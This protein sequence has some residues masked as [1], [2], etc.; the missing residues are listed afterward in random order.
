MHAEIAFVAE[1]EAPGKMAFRAPHAFGN[2]IDFAAVQREERDD[3][4]G[5]AERPSA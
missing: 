5:F 4:I 3:A 2:G 1:L